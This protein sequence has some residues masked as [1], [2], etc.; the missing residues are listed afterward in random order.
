MFVNI[1]YYIPMDNMTVTTSQQD[2]SIYIKYKT[3]N[4]D[5]KNDTLSQ[6][7]NKM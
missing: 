7:V 4:G 2:N 3:Y 1:K 6:L 5:E